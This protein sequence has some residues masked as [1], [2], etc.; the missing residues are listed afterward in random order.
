MHSDKGE[1][2]GHYVEQKMPDTKEYIPCAFIYVKFKD[3]QKHRGRNQK[4]SYLWV[5]KGR[6]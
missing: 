3:R 6:G 5:E 2:H 1:F 4:V